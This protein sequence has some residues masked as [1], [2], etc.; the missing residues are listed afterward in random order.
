[1]FVQLVAPL[2]LRL[3]CTGPEMAGYWNSMSDLGWSEPSSGSVPPGEVDELERARLRAEIDALAAL[4]VFG[5]DATELE[6][7]LDSFDV[8]NRSEERN[9]GE[10]RPSA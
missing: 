10:P 4:H 1:M 2:V 6:H 9:L 7:V 3:C 5:L 8:L